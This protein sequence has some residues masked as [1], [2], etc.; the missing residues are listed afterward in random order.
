[1]NLTTISMPKKEARAA[2][3]EYRRAVRQRHNAEDEAIMRGYRA[4]SLGR[5]IIDLHQVMREA[6]VAVRRAG[7][8]GPD[9]AGAGCV[10]GDANGGKELMLNGLIID[11]FA[12]GG[13]AS[14]G[15]K[16]AVGRSPDIA[17]NHDADAI[18]MHTANHPETLHVRE[19]VWLTKLRDLVNGRPVWFLWLSPD[20]KDFSRAKGGVPVDKRIR[21]LAWVAVKWASQIRPRAIFLEN[22]REFAEWGPLLP[23]WEC[24]GCQWEG[25][26][27]QATLARTRRR[28]PRCNSLRI[29]PTDRCIPDPNKRGMT[30]RLFCNR[31]RGLGY[32]VEYRNLN[33]ADY[34]APTHRRRLFLVARCDGQPIEWPEATHGDARKVDQRPLF[35]PKLRPWRTAAECIDWSIPCPSIFGRKRELKPATLRRIALGLKRYVLENPQPFIVGVGGAEY[36][37]KPRSTD[38][39]FSTVLP[40]DRK[41][42]VTPYFVP[43]TH[44]GERRA[45]PAGEPLPTITSANG[46]EFAVVAPVIATLAHGEATGTFGDSRT[47][48]VEKPLTTIHAGGGNHALVAAFMAKHYGGMVGV[49][50]ESP[51]TTTTARGTQNQLVAANLVHLN[52]GDKQWSDLREPMRTVTTG[53]HAALVYSF[54]VKYFGTAIGQHLTDPLHTIT[55]KDRFGLVTVTIAGELYVI[56]D[57]GMRMLKARELATAQGF[58]SDYVLTGSNTSQ[59]AKIGN[60]VSPHVAEALVRANM[61]GLFTYHPEMGDAKPEA[62]I[63]ASLSHYGRRY[64]LCTP[65]ELKG[66][67]IEKIGTLKS[68]DLTPT[69]QHKVG[70]HDYKVTE[71]AFEKICQ[72]YSVSYEMLLD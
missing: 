21:S 8:V 23:L 16:R 33:A 36:A 56:V 37:A 14:L 51:L 4:M 38:A 9:A 32:T 25:T 57:I 52:Y 19:D 49:P 42:L 5:Q 26:E 54:L 63:E 6:G 22:V 20:C 17:I 29:R 40:H 47:H 1:M 64:F 10:G 27:G 48:H 46:G 39:P 72:Q 71:K 69:A 67:G 2:F 12:G 70:W 13:G 15:I 59:V 44:S 30:F 41:A 35:G 11:G 65:L 7:D 58:D 50:V 34:G 45:H 61:A 18:A 68:G 53:K 60:S 28:C 55:G 24:R 3:L 31:L 43:V 66:R 62:Q